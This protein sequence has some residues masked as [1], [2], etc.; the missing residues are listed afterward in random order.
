MTS[1]EL[2]AKVSKLEQQTEKNDKAIAKLKKQVAE[3]KY[4][5]K[6]LSDNSKY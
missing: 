5:I 4:L 3:C 1:E 2:Q 6:I